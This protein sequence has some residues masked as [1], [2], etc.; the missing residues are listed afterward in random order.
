MRGIFEIIGIALVVAFYLG[1]PL[2]GVGLLWWEK[3]HF[4][5]AALLSL[6][7]IVWHEKSP[8][9]QSRFLKI[10]RELAI[11]IAGLVLMAAFAIALAEGYKLIFGDPWPSYDYGD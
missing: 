2:I 5:S 1:I 7:L 4:F 3:P 6:G 9:A 10:V 11:T 8:P